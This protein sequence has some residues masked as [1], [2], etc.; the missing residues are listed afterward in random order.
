MLAGLE[1]EGDGQVR[2]ADAGRAQQQDVVPRFEIAAGRQ[3][4]DHFR[5]DGWL[6]FEVE[7]IERLLK[8]KARHRDAHGEVLLGLGTDLQGEEL[9]E[10]IGVRDVAFGGLLEQRGQLGLET[11]EAQALT[12]AAQ[13][14]EAGCSL[15]TADR[16]QR[17]VD[18]QVA[19]FDGAQGVIRRVPLR[20][21]GHR[22]R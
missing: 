15:A 4:A 17:L 22:R 8:G 13:P 11:M 21:L 7:G 12:V 20:R 3:L 10:E 1:T 16:T 9:V 6:E 14:I 2:L 18:G 19:D 5:I